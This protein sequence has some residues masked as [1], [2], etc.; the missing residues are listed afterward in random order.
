MRGALAFRGRQDHGD[1]R[2][3]A[4]QCGRTVARGECDSPSHELRH[5]LPQRAGSDNAAVGK[6]VWSAGRAAQRGPAPFR[7][8]MA[9]PHRPELRRLAENLS[10]WVPVRTRLP[11]LQ[12]DR[13]VQPI[14]AKIPKVGLEP[15]PP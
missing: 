3:Q 12:Y 7:D 15:T 11:R 13:S 5:R 14:A 4:R 2:C 10:N 1:E 6:G 9:W 8:T